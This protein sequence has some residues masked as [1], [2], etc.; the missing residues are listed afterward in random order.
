[1]VRFKDSKAG[2]LISIFGGD[3]QSLSAEEKAIMATHEMTMDVSLAMATGTISTWVQLAR[4]YDDDKS[5]SNQSMEFQR[6]A[7]ITAASSIGMGFVLYGSGLT[8][9]EF[10]VGRS[11]ALRPVTKI[12]YHPIVAVPVL[13]VVATA[14]YPEVAGPMFQSSMSGQPGIGSA[15]GDLIF[16]R[17]SAKVNSWGEFLDFILPWRGL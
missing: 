9:F 8:S 17:S 10:A 2:K 5:L 13:S 3:V 1:M 4:L 14:K 12:A 6:Q 16:G 15:G 11:V 7:A